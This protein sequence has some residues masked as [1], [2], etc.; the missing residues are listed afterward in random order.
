MGM[1][2]APFSGVLYSTF[3]YVHFIP[4]SLYIVFCMLHFSSIV[5][6]D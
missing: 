3:D 5:Y 4:C 6:F 1:S 2:S